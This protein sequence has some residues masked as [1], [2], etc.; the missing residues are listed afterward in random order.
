MHRHGL[1]GIWRDDK[2]GKPMGTISVD[3]VDSTKLIKT[4]EVENINSTLRKGQL[5]DVFSWLGYF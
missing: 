2:Y 1:R 5:K 3:G 4:Y